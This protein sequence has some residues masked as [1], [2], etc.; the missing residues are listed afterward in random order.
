MKIT[1]KFK[2]IKILII[3]FI[4]TLLFC[5]LNINTENFKLFGVRDC[6]CEKKGLEKA[7]GPTMCV[8]E[9][10]KFDLHKNCR[11]IDPKTGFCIECYPK[12]K[13]PFATLVSKKH[14]KKMLRDS[15]Y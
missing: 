7:Y 8:F 15:G 1:Y 5:I 3:I 6:Y 10:G 14:W 12:V 2:N 4:I 13:K 11:C 9:D